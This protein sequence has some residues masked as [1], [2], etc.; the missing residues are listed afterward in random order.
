MLGLALAQLLRSQ[1]N[2]R[3]LRTA[4][5]SAE[6]ISRLGIQPQVT[7]DELKTGLSPTISGRS[8]SAVRADLDSGNLAGLRVWNT[9][10]RWCTPT[11]RTSVGQQLTPSGGLRTA[12]GGHTSSKKEAAHEAEEEKSESGGTEPEFSGDLLEVYVPLR[13]TGGGRPAGA[14]ELYLPYAPVAAAIKED[15]R[16]LYLVLIAGLAL[17][18]VGSSG[19]WPAPRSGCAATPPRTSTRRCTTRSPGCPTAPC[20]TTASSRRCADAPRPR[21]RRGAAASTWTASRRSTTRSA[22]RRRP[23]AEGHRRAGCAAALRDE[24]HVARLGGDEFGVLLPTV[25]DG[26]GA[27]RRRRRSA[28]RSDADSDRRPARAHRR[29]RGHRALPAARRGR[30][31]AAPARR[32][33]HVRGQ[34]HPRAAERLLGRPRPLQPGRLA[35]VG[36]LRKALEDGE[37]V[38]HYQPKIDLGYRA[39]SSGWR[40]WCAGSTRRAG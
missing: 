20:S 18:Y 19:W 39:R 38:L 24:R 36:Q 29:E 23:A 8:T 2:D 1:I 11:R 26:A 31:H 13:F 21:A 15:T 16:T 10:G 22:T 34:A 27:V 35:M 30:G 7:P 4:E 37:V 9:D 32:R 14:F 12:L 6:Q 33:G 3:A 17:L 25:G 28:P 40:R 5:Q